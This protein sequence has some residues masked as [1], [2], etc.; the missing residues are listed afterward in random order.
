MTT[1]APSYAYIT[2]KG[3]GLLINQTEIGYIDFTQVNQTNILLW[4]ATQIKGFIFAG[5][6]F[7]SLTQTMSLLIGHM[8]V[9]PDW[10]FDGVV[11]GLEGGSTLVS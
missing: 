5:E 9:Q 7:K 3:Y 4:R 8:K 2:N 10:I 6:S 11:V 1:Y